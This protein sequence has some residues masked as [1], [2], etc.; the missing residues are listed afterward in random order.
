MRLRELQINV[1]STGP[2]FRTRLTFPDGLVVVRADNSMGKSTCFKSILVALGMEAMLTTSQTDLPLTPAVTTELIGQDGTYHVIESDIY[3]E[4]ENSNKRR[5]T[6]HR[7]VKGERDSHLVTVIDGPALS[8]PGAY[9]SRDFFV[10]RPGAASRDAGFHRFLAEFLGWTLPLVTTFEGKDSPLYL[11][12]IFPYVFVEQKRGWSTIQPPEPTQFRIKDVH[13]RAVEFLLRFDAYTIALRRQELLAERSR[14]QADWT[15]LVGR[16]SELARG[17]NGM[18]QSLPTAPVSSWPPEVQPSIAVPVGED[19]KTLD[20]YL[21]L[22]KAELRQL[23]TQEIP[24]VQEITESAESDLN[25]FE[26]VLR[27]REALL[28]RLLNSLDSEQA[29][30]EAA[31]SRL[32]SI[33]E[34]LQRNKDAQTL[35]R[36]GGQHFSAISNGTCPICHQVLQDSL[37]PLE[38][39]QTVMPLEAN[40]AFL[41]DQ[42]RTFQ[43][44]L[45]EAEHVASARER[46]AAALRNELSELRERI[47]VLRQTLISDGRLPSAAAIQ[48]RLELDRNIQQGQ[49]ILESFNGLLGEFAEHS[50][51]WREV[52]GNLARLPSDDTAEEDRRRIAK[53]TTLLQEQLRQYGFGS[54]ATDQIVVSTDTYRPEHEGFDLQTSISASDLIRTIWAYLVGMLELSRT[55]STNHPG[56]LVFD[57]PRQQST[58]DVSFVQLLKRASSASACG[59]QVVFFTSEEPSRLNNGLAGVGHSLLEFKGRLIE[60]V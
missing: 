21:R 26:R 28:S 7:T 49:S 8:N 29:E 46:Q 12:T 41:E 13:R 34:D 10:N 60:R 51:Q 35:I 23:V 43:A 4:I 2:A 14:I 37:I 45:L 19:W 31:K 32:M 50:D 20:E 9:S 54:L 15:N 5:V 6:V 24:R 38:V 30:I 40:I 1:Q 33:N 11:Q 55:D 58:K 25:R 57:E 22:S 17:R 16:A 48:A 47:R 39:Q 59:Q 27:N 42:R 53:W 52:V 3:L 36:L 18:T 44:V 56:L